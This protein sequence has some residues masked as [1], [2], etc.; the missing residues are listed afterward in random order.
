MISKKIF[1]ADGSNKRFL[2]DFII[3]SEQFTRVYNY[4]LDINGVEEAIE[5]LSG[6]SIRRVDVPNS[7]DLV[8]VDKWDLVDN[9][10]SFYSSPYVGS[11]VYIEVASSPE[12]FG[13]TLIQPSV[14]KAEAA[15]AGAL[16]AK[17]TADSYATEAENVLVKIYTSNGNGTFTATNTTE[18]SSLHYKNKA[19]VFNPALYAPLASPALTNTPTAPT[20]P[21]GTNTTQLATTEFTTT[22]DNLRTKKAEIAYNN[23]TLAFIPNT[24]PSGAII[25]NGSNANGSYIKYADGTLICTGF[26]NAT[27][28]NARVLRFTITFPTAFINNSVVVTGGSSTA[29]ADTNIVYNALNRFV[30]TGHKNG[31]T[32]TVGVLDIYNLTDSISFSAGEYMNNCDYLAIGRWK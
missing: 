32:N 31:N 5:P 20:A 24:L 15:A 13:D 21:A 19:S 16:A 30:A 7:N 12:E 29:S 10:I 4:I 2:S 14:E 8:T 3:R 17:M 1:A 25:E 18:Y 22:S 27:Y 11:R 28:N 26:G 9:S 23:N 6:L